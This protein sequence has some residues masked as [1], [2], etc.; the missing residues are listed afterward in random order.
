TGS[1]NIAIG[2][3]ALENNKTGS[4]NIGI[5]EEAQMIDGLTN[6]TVIGSNA[7]VN[8]SNS[9]VLGNYLVNVGIGTSAPTNKLE[10][11]NANTPG[12]SGLR[13]TSLTATSA[14]NGSVLSID[15]TTK[16]VILVPAS[17]GGTIPTGPA[18]GNFW[19]LTGNSGTTPGIGAGQNFMGTTDNEDVVFARNGIQSGLL[20]DAS[21]NTS[22]GEGA[23]Q[24]NVGIN[25]TAIGY[26]A[27]TNPIGNE[28]TAVGERALYINTQG[29]ENVALGDEALA[30]NTMGTG[31]VGIGLGTLSTN[32]IG[33][34]N[35]A[36]GTGANVQPDGVTNSTAVGYDAVV[37]GSNIMA[38]GNENVLGWG[39]GAGYPT[40]Q[41]VLVVGTT[42]SA[43]P[44]GNGAYLTAGGDWTNT[45]DRNLK[46]DFST[47][48]SKD[49]LSRIN[50]LSITKWKYKG[51]S[52]YHVGP[53]AQD[54]YSSF[55]LGTDNTHISTIDPAG[56]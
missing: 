48:D 4:S 51:T 27:L 5:G 50:K 23:L 32:A 56:V 9:M 24:P 11:V 28:N 30:S 53:M 42:T 54:F 34:F 37:T 43:I 40:S 47:L 2:D 8:T 13:L 10:I 46:E 3:G 31:N 55:N 6:A 21:H 17:S 45:S 7:Q 20:N 38:F 22:W 14:P 19:S 16:D 49:V 18:N 1:F 52:E 25:N 35:T 15:P 44:N 41:H 12:N 39:F 29:S 36:I 26:Y 33:N